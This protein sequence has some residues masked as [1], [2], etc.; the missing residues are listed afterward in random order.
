VARSIY[1]YTDSRVLGGAEHA[2]LMLIGALDRNAWR[3]TLLL[4]GGDAAALGE[5]ARR[6]DAGVRQIAPMP[7]GLEGARRVPGLVRLLRAERPAV[8]HA[9]LSWPLAAKYALAAAVIS[10]V[11][12]VVATV[13]LIPQFEPGRSSLVQL[14]ALA[15]GVDRYIAVSHDIA[16]E[17][18][19]RFR[20]PASKVEV[21]HNAVEVERFAGPAPPGLREQLTGKPDRPVVL[22]CARLHEQK[23]HRTLLR[24][25]T[26]VPEAV[27][28]LAGEG[29]ERAALESLAEEL[30]VSDRV[31]FLGPR[32]DVPALLAACDVFALP[33][34]YEGS[35]LA[36]LE[37]MAA[38]RAVVASAIGGTEE[39]IDDGQTGLLVAPDDPGALAAALRRLLGD[40]TLRS[41]LA[42]RARQV[43]ESRFT[44]DAMARRVECIYEEIL[45]DTS[46]VHA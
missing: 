42:G 20:W 29:P 30:E 11:P 19:E 2:L 35:S 22:T 8:F 46:R 6:L 45:D 14:R 17:L 25:A 10:R 34:L 24:A 13:Q 4:G 26:E 32:A 9:H 18:I 12:A 3:T 31:R 5:E 23:G 36:I 41:S 37:A 16:T 27:F 28:A 1:H 44:R 38:G 7:L 15:A 40:R 21:V 33:S 43:A 39:L